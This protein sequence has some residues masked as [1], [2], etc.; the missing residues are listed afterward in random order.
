MRQFMRFLALLF[1]ALSLQALSPPKRPKL[2]LAIII[3]QFRYDYLLK[4]RAEFHSGLARLL[5]QGAVFADAQYLQATTVTAIGHSTFL[6]GAPPAVSGIIGNDWYDREV[7]D[8]VTSVMD[9]KV[10]Q[11]GGFAGVMGSSPRRLLTSTV[12]DEIKLA[13]IKSKSIS[14][15]IKDRSAILPIGR[16]GDA[17]YWYD[18]DQY[19]WVTSDY[20]RPDLPAWAK[21]VN[22]R[23]SYKQYEGAK[24]FPLGAKEGSAKPLCSMFNNG[25]MRF[26]GGLEATP[27]GNEMIEEFAERALDE[28]QLG[29]HDGT[30][31]L[32]ISFSA[33]DYVGHAVGPDDPAVHDITIRTDRLLGK[34]LDYIDTKVGAGNTLLVMTADHGVAPVPEAHARAAGGRIDAYSLDKRMRDALAHRFGPGEWIVGGSAAMPY[35]NLEL[36]RTKRLNRD[37]VEN[38]AAE[39]ALA[40]P[41][42]ARVYTHHQLMEGR[43]ALDEIGRAFVLSFYAPRSGD[44]MILQEPGYLFESTGTSHGTPYRYDTHVPIVFAGPGIKPGTYSGRIAPNDI[45]PTLSFLLGIQEPSGSIGRILREALE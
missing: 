29:R 42:I 8:K 45:A 36:I 2:L 18:G 25:E 7:K 27:W 15:S 28:E 17:A 34:L 1:L 43:L 32:A 37:E 10:K 19:K 13:G 3:D 41:H 24:W 16:M 23:E 11:V 30:D 40:E 26:C 31:V 33:N 4:Y 12:A 44:V 21:A 5:E 9:Q 14:V 22:N 38:V 20:Y 6:T 39:A 35:L